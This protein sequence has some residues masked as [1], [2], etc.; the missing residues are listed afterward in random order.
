MTFATAVVNKRWRTL[1]FKVCQGITGARDKTVPANIGLH[2][3]FACNS[4]AL[5]PSPIGMGGKGPRRAV[6]VSGREAMK[7]EKTVYFVRHGQSLANVSA[8]FQGP[9]SPLSETG[10]SQ[11]RRIAER[12][13]KLSCEALISSPFR[14][15]G[16]TAAAIARETGLVP[17]YSKLFVERLKPSSI[18]G[19]PFN[20]EDARAIWME[21]ERSLYTLAKRVEDGENFADLIARADNALTFLRDRKEASL[22]VVT[23][24][25]FLRTVVARAVL[26]GVLSA[27]VFKR[28]QRV[29]SMENTGLTV[30]RYHQAFDEEP[31]WRLWIYNDHAH[32]G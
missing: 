7:L 3:I 2:A 15:A 20:D 22:A 26:G 17:E 9:D 11:A 14:R 29:A 10:H 12:V 5:S 31:D 32:L 30:L 16:E 21:W 13:S 23:H 8:V 1:R 18:N 28:F 4:A 25:F 24:G 6:Q 27:E 19:R